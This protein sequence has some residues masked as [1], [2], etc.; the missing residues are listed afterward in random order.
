[1]CQGQLRAAG[2]LPA[3]QR[4]LHD[5]PAIAIILLHCRGRKQLWAGLG[6]F[7]AELEM[8]DLD[9]IKQADQGLAVLPRPIRPF[10]PATKA[11]TNAGDFAADLL[12]EQQTVR[13]CFNESL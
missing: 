11:A 2:T 6:I 1:M 13:R 8:P 12:Q 4:F 9:L 5:D 10:E 3:I 7:D